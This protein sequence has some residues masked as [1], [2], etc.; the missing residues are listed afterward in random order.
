MGPSPVGPRPE[1]LVAISFGVIFVVP[2]LF[3]ITNAA[4]TRPLH[5]NIRRLFSNLTKNLFLTEIDERRVVAHDEDDASGRK[6]A[7]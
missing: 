1:I 2:L 4:D 3:W 5:T 7:E 6:F